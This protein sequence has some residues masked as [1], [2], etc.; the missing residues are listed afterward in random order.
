MQSRNRFLKLQLA[1]RGLIGDRGKLTDKLEDLRVQV[2]AIGIDHENT[3]NVHAAIAGMLG[4][5]TQGLDGKIQGGELTKTRKSSTVDYVKNLVPY[6]DFSSWESPK[7]EQGENSEESERKSALEEY[8]RWA[9]EGIAVEASDIQC[10][11]GPKGS[12]K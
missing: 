10:T 11:L 1:L 8:K 2:L 4:P 7:G 3:V 12:G 6:R 5:M 9:K